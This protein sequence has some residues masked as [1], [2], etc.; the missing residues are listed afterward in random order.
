MNCFSEPNLALAYH[1]RVCQCKTM[2][3]VSITNIYCLCKNQN[4]K[5]RLRAQCK[6]LSKRDS[7]F[8]PLPLKTRFDNPDNDSQALERGPSMLG[9]VRLI[10]LINNNPNTE[11]RHFPQRCWRIIRKDIPALADNRIILENW[12]K[13]TPIKG[14]LWR[15]KG[16]GSIDHS[17]VLR[18]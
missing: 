2:L 15:K 10:W 4:W 13:P 12:Q 3:E 16:F 6:C 9:N 18:K 7:S 11:V 17:L 8:R 5:W 1:N 14:L